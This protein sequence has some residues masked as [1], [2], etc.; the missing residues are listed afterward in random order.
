M[1]FGSD[2]ARASGQPR[3]M[4]SAAQRTTQATKVS[5]SSECW[6]SRT[7]HVTSV[8][9][10][11]KMDGSMD[12]EHGVALVVHFWSTLVFFGLPRPRFTTLFHWELRHVGRSLVQDGSVE[13]VKN[14]RKVLYG[15]DDG[16]LR[17]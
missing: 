4:R 2:R 1:E 13:H 3:A 17:S 5:V 10:S 12:R 16:V 6:V 7:G 8:L 11:T 15:H 14:E 9:R